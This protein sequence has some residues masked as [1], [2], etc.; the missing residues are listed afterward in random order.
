MAIEFPLTQ[1]PSDRKLSPGSHPV[2]VFTALNGAETPVLL[3]D[4]MT[5]ATITAS[6]PALPDADA[7]KAWTA[8]RS[9]YSGAKSV[10]LPPGLLAG[11]AADGVEFPAYLDW[12]IKEEPVLGSILG[13][14]G[15]SSVSLVM[16]GRLLA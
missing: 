11:L 5:G 13:A 8:W 14:P 16:R 6:W 1:V 10:E 4:R 7:Q 2:R 3:G 12:T 9:C 15:Y